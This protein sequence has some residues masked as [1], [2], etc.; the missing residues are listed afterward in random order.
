MTDPT[1]SPS[2]LIFDLDGTLLDSFPGHFQAYLTMFAHFGIPMSAESFFAVYSPNWLETYRKVGLPRERWAEADAVWIA[3]A[4]KHE[5]QLFPGARALLERLAKR[6]RLGL[7]TSGTGQRVL[8]DLE[9]TGIRGLFGVVITGG[10]VAHP[11]PHP[12]GLELALSA[13]DT[14]PA[15][16]VYIG[17]A[18]ADL[19]MS[20]SAGVRFIGI[21]SQFASLPADAP[22]QV[23]SALEDLLPLFDGDER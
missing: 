18:L 13:L 19:Q 23:V 16:A 11:K 3:E 8:D 10:D 20:Q 21:P 7:V 9:R 2:A 22:C 6:Y 17:D 4:R 12:E 15:G 1:P 5:T 14:S